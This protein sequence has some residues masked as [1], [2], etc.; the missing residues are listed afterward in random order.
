MDG[1]DES[2]PATELLE[3]LNA[4]VGERAA[5]ERE[6]PKRAN[7]LSG[8]LK[9]AAPTLRKVGIYVTFP[10]R[11]GHASAKVISITVRGL[12]EQKPETSSA[13]STSA[14]K[15]KKS[16]E[17]NTMCDSDAD[18]LPTME[19]SA[20]VGSKLLNIKA[21][22]DAAG[23]DD[24]FPL[25]SDAHRGNGADNRICAQC[26]AGT[27][28]DPPTEKVMNGKGEAVWLHAGRC[29]QFWVEEHTQQEN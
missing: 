11:E 23:A 20:I 26:G 17:V 15:N 4:I 3:A 13:A 9:R 18:D 27:P 14:A 16:N 6:W 19:S 21:A 12:P 1:R 28:D 25:Q 2:G 8:K 29:R 5:K 22:D 7:T 10:A 24:D